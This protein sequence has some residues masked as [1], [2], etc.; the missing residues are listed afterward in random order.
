MKNK[1]MNP[2]GRF[3]GLEYIDWIYYPYLDA[4]FIVYILRNPLTFPVML[5]WSPRRGYVMVKWLLL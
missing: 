1:E 3:L 4:R 2:L 5:P